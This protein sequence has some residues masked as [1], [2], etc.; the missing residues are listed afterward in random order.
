MANVVA[1]IRCDEH[2]HCW[3]LTV[4]TMMMVRHETYTVVDQIREAI[5]G[6]RAGVVGE[7]LEIAD[8]IIEQYGGQETFLA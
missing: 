5:H 6:H 7:C 3:H 1:L 2:Q 8:S 4:N